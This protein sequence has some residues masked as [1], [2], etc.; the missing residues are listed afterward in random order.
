MKIKNHARANK[1][2]TT[3]PE[4]KQGN[5]KIKLLVTG[6]V[7]L[8]L[9]VWV[10]FLSTKATKTID[11]CMYTEDTYKNQVISDPESQFMKYSMNLTEYEKYTIVDDNGVKSRRILLW[12]DRADATG[13]FV[14]YPS[15]AETYVMYS[16]LIVSKTDNSDSVMYSY[17]GKVITSLEVESS[18][19]DAFKSFLQPGDRIN[20]SAVYKLNTQLSDGSGSINTVETQ[21]TETVFNDIMLA[22]LLNSDGESILDIYADYNTRSVYE[23]EQLNSN[24]TFTDS[25]KPSKILVALTKEELLTYYRYC[26]GKDCN[27]R[28]T[29]NQRG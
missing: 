29:L 22:D 23:Q 9:I 13:T 28:V 19:L 21:K 20:V 4:K 1:E 17:P 5:K 7:A 25:V 26:Y 3:K 16:D 2:T 10:S 6:V 11:V 24:T 12:E 27:F 14:A 8:G 15:A 18:D